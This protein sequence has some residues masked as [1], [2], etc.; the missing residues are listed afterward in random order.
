VPAEVV[1]DS[2]ALRQMLTNLVGNAIKFTRR[3]QVIVRTDIEQL[4]EPDRIGLH[5]AVCDTGI[6]IPP[7][8]QQAIFEPFEQA[9]GSSTRR[10][11]G[12]GLG[13][14]I[15]SR[16]VEMMGGR[17]S[18][19]SEPGTGSTFHVVVPFDA[20][21]SATNHSA[22]PPQPPPAGPGLS[23]RPPRALRVLLVEDNPLNQRVACALLEKHGHSVTVAEDGRAAVELTGRE[24]FD[25]AL[26][27]VEM[28]EMNG[29]EAVA[30][31]RRRESAT[32]A[33][34]PI[35]AMTAHALAGDREKCLAAGMDAYVS[36][37]VRVNDLLA[38]VEHVRAAH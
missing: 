5:V 23:P 30:A 33:Y 14:A 29:I 7:E 21:E 38:A 28:P 8:R 12:T 2:Q 9:D 20:V 6:G 24:P 36:K 37:P 10:F 17:I 13:L 32:G 34:L 1:G 27:D 18:V 4:A 19:E 15:A 26:M 25:L 31:I 11:G 22:T 35:I 16:L 3:G